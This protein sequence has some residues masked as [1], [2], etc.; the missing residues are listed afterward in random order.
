MEELLYFSM[1]STQAKEKAQKLLGSY[2]GGQP[3]IG[4]VSKLG[5]APSGN[6]R[7]AELVFPP[8]ITALL[9]KACRQRGITVTSAVHAAYVRMLMEHADPESDQSRYTSMNQFNLRPYLPA[10][11]NSSKYAASV[12]YAP[13]PHI[14]ELPA[15]YWDLATSFSEYYKTTFKEDPGLLEV[16][17]HFKRGMQ[18]FV[19]SPEFLTAPAPKDALVSSLGIVENFINREYGDKIKVKDFKFGADIVLGMSMLF[20]YTFQDKLRL[21]YSFNDG[22]EKPEDIMMSLRKVQWILIQELLL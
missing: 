5:S 16:T 1:D 8:D 11:Y 9:I 20:F 7:N 19:S 13:H 2:L 6:S 18:D 17:G 14:I 12:Y 22:F 21:V 10:P 3:A 15:S 4:P